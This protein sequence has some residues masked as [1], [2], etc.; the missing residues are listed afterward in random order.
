MSRVVQVGVASRE[1]TWFGYRHFIPTILNKARELEF[2]CWL[3]N[4]Y[5]PP[6]DTSAAAFGFTNPDLIQT[7]SNQKTNNAI[8]TDYPRDN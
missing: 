6:V 3:G 5:C 2:C 8:L 4:R 7:S 1:L